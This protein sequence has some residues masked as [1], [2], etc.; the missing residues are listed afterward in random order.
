MISRCYDTIS[1]SKTQARLRL[2]LDKS[3]R[4]RAWVFEDAI[5]YV[6]RYLLTLLFN[7]EFNTGL[8]FDDGVQCSRRTQPPPKLPD[9]PAHK[10][11]ANYYFT[12]DERRKVEPP[13]NFYVAGKSQLES[14][15]LQHIKSLPASSDIPPPPRMFTPGFN[16]NWETGKSEIPDSQ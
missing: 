2:L 7:D 15:P 13:K 6:S 11:S 8:R 1:S 12:R 16:Y 4:N 10:L 9:G 3:K 5:R 14:L